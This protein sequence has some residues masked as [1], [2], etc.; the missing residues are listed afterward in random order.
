M[1]AQAAAPYSKT[2]IAQRGHHIYDTQ[3]RSQV[4]A[5]HHG[6]IVAIDIATGD[7]TIAID[8]LTAA[9]ELL[10]HHTE[11]QI[12]CIRIGHR[13]VHRLTRSPFPRK[14]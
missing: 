13:A 3:I 14:N 5:D 9:K 11:A 4:E 2:E 6:E 8:S 10:T 12:F 1:T 7:F